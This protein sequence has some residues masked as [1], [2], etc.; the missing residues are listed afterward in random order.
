MDTLEEILAAELSNYETD[1]L[2]DVLAE[3][4]VPASDVQNMDEVFSDSQ[5][6][7]RGM[8]ATVEHPT[9]GTVKMPG[10]PMHFSRTP[11]RI[12]RYP[13]SLGEHTE[14]VLREYN[15]TDSD[16][17][18]LRETGTIPQKD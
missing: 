7:A 11:V 4:G 14:E 12:D 5:V 17:T 2:L 13:P 15:Y 18:H 1:A 16:L 10:S 8:R 9:A 6:Q 3:Y